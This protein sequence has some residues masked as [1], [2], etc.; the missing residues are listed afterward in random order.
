MAPKGGLTWEGTKMNQDAQLHMRWIATPSAH[1]GQKP[2]T[3]WRA[4]VI[5][6]DGCWF[7]EFSQGGRLITSMHMDSLEDAKAQ[8]EALL[9]GMGL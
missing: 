6:A 9:E 3:T 4:K 8:A 5:E 2:G 1:Y 7:L